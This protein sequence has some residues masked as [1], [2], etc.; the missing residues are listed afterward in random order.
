MKVAQQSMSPPLKPSISWQESPNPKNGCKPEWHLVKPNYG[1]SNGGTGVPACV[2]IG[3]C[4]QAGTPVPPNQEQSL[5]ISQ[6]SLTKRHSCKPIFVFPGTKDDTAF[7]ILELLV[8]ATI[9]AIIAGLLLSMFS[10]SSDAWLASQENVERQRSA[11]VALELISRDLSQALISTSSP[12]IDFF[13][14]SNDIYFIT[15]APSQP[16]QISDME[17]IGYRLDINNGKLYRYS[18]PPTNDVSSHTWNPRANSTGFLPLSGVPNQ[19]TWP[20]L[21]NIENF[22]YTDDAD[23]LIAD[24]IIDL[25]FKYYSNGSKPF[26][27]SWTTSNSFIGTTF[28]YFTNSLPPIVDVNLIVMPPGKWKP[29]GSPNYAGLTNR[30]SRIYQG[31]IHIIRGGN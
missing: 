2:S 25:Q 23:A 8:A 26:V 22:L 21:T 27:P 24:G 11:R 12:A 5:G 30:Y 10:Q 9:L 28:D 14:R 16:G 19:W 31:T 15:T 29:P 17:E 4:S 13:G 1:F 7:T 18:T 6:K 3:G 20:T